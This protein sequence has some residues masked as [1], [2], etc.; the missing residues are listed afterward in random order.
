MSDQLS[1]LLKQY[2]NV[3]SSTIGHVLDTGYLPEIHAVNSIQHVVGIVR[4]VTL[5]S[6]NAMQ[7][8]N[9][10][11]ESKAGDVLVI[12]ARKLGYRACWGEQ[13]HRAAIYHQLAAIVVIGAVTD[14]DAL[15]TMKV[16]VFAQTVSCLTTRSEGESLVDFD[17]DIQYFDSTISTGDLMIADAD[18]VFILKPDIAAQYLEKFQNMELLEK[19]K[20][21]QFFKQHSLEQYYHAI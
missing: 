11:L 2:A 14:I 7:I 9:A 21:D 13:R 15:R 16:P 18:G 19:Q 3:A 20:R 4:T 8:R 10:L 6:I 1:I 5:N 17:Q 12:D